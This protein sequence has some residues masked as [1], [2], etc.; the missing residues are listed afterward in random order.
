KSLL[1][2][3]I[4]NGEGYE[5]RN[6]GHDAQVRQL[7]QI[8]RAEQPNAWF[9]FTGW[10]YESVHPLYPVRAFASFCDADCPEDY[11][12]QWSV[13]PEMALERARVDYQSAMAGD[14][15]VGRCQL[16]SAGL[17]HSCTP[18]ELRRFLASKDNGGAPSLWVWEYATEEL[19][20]A[21][22]LHTS[23]APAPVAPP[24]CTVKGAQVMLTTCGFPC[25]TPDGRLGGE[26]QAALRSYQKSRGLSNT[27]RLDA[28]TMA[29]MNREYP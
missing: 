14:P 27:G 15:D 21:V 16:S 6:G 8:I 19:W 20:A 24:V 28:G 29:R 12:S 25:G 10:T 26:T 7:G 13:P 5:E 23:G 2:G 17:I 18:D 3:F 9:G 22:K 4:L 1:S 11:W